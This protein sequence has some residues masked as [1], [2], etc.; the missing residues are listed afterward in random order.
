MSPW[1]GFPVLCLILLCLSATIRSGARWTSSTLMQGIPDGTILALSQLIIVSQMLGLFGYLDAVRLLVSH[2]AV[3]AAVWVAVRYA[4]P[5]VIHTPTFRESTSETG[6][7]TCD[8]GYLFNDHGFLL[9]TMILLPLIAATAALIQAA[10]R[11][12]G[13]TDV[14]TYHMSFP[15]EWHIWRDLRCTVQHYGDPGPPFYP[16]H[17]ALITHLLMTPLH[18]DIL[19]RFHQIPMFLIGWIALARGSM[20][21]GASRTAAWTA[22]SMAAMMPLAVSWL[23]LSFSDISL[24]GAIALVFYSAARLDSRSLPRH[25]FVFGLATGLV[26]GFK[27]FGLFYA[28]S[29]CAWGLYKLLRN[30]RLRFIGPALWVFGAFLSGSFWF[31]RNWIL[32]GNPVFPYQI[33]IFGRIIFPGIYG[34]TNVLNHGFRR[35]DFL[36]EFQLPELF[37]TMG[38]PGFI[39]VLS[40]P[41]CLILVLLKRQFRWIYLVPVIMGVQFLYLPYRY[42]PRFL[43]PALWMSVPCAA[44]VLDTVFKTRTQKPFS[45]K[46]ATTI[47][48]I[49]SIALTPYGVFRSWVVILVSLILAGILT[50]KYQTLFSI[51]N[52]VK[53]RTMIAAAVVFVAISAAF[54]FASRLYEQN[55]WG[56]LDIELIDITGIL[57]EINEDTPHLNIAYSGFHTPYPLWGQ[58]LTNR[59]RFLALDGRSEASWTGSTPL[60][61]PNVVPDFDGWRQLVD[62]TKTDFI[63]LA[64]FPGERIPVEYHWVRRL[65]DFEL[66]YM[67]RV[68]QAWKRSE[69]QDD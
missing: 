56:H 1:Y 45:G 14:W 7:T 44:V 47:A 15:A 24:A 19:G 53:R 8:S 12:P 48:L 58:F 62:V 33:E 65:D 22:A 17:S 29:I 54:P 39:L 55:K 28:L 27:A 42:H 63:V 51:D 21:M 68:F 36:G 52:L 40:V 30:K 59:V 31:L 61:S 18:S 5:I 23:P 49:L 66:V 20:A 34:R 50:L 6:V 11:G 10:M 43:L 67:T 32:Q 16:H 57:A 2:A 37:R 9:R 25:A 46:T 26:S 60:I 64:T 69:K 3:S 4:K 13:G 38:V 41:V 35:L